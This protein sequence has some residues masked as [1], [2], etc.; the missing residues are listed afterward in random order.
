MPGHYCVGGNVDI[1]DYNA[2]AIDTNFIC[3]NLTFIKY[4]HEGAT[5][6]ETEEQFPP[7]PGL[8]EDDE[9]DSSSSSET[10]DDQSVMRRRRGKQ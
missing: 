3:K 5:I 8:D 6:V 1:V 10:S 4:T 7:K 9:D 2:T